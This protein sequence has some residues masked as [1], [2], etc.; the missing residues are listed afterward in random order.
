MFFN[1]FLERALSQYKIHKQVNL[2]V[3]LVIFCKICVLQDKNNT[4]LELNKNN[5]LRGLSDFI[6]DYGNTYHTC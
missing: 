1:C 2:L 3:K 5:N 6:L 4:Y